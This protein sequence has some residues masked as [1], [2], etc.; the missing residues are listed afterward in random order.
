MFL[1][2]MNKWMMCIWK[3]K[4]PLKVKIFL[5]K[6]CNDKIQSTEQLKAKNWNGPLECKLCGEVES[7]SHIF[8]ECAVAMFSWRVVSDAVGWGSPPSNMMDL[9]SKLVEGSNIENNYFVFL[10]GCLAWG[11][12][13]IR[14]DL[15]FNN[16]VASTPD[17]GVLRMIS[18]M[19]KW[20]V[21]HKEKAQRWIGSVICKLRHQLSSLNSE[22]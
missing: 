18:F 14:N 21:L 20:S 13:L 3:A 4:L 17:V 16:I 5:W 7:T 15:I 1:G 11:L 22:D 10:F 8:L 19:Q 6:V 9:H 2:V 12:W